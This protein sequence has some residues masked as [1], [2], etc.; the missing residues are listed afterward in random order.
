MGDAAR[1]RRRISLIVVT[2]NSAPLVTTAID[3]AVESAVAAD[4]ELEIIVVDNASSDGT[5]DL[6]ERQY[7]DARVLRNAANVGFAA[8][9]NQAFRQASGDVWLLLNPDATVERSAL[10]H[11]VGFLDARGRAAAAA[12]TVEDGRGGGAE[13]AGMTPGLRSLASH[14]LMINRLLVGDRGGA[15]RGF[16]LARRPRLGPRS[17]DWVGG[18]ALLSRAEAIRSVGGFDERFFLYGEDV[19]LGA[20]LRDRGW[21][22]WLVPAA[23][24][25]HLIAGSQGRVSTR[26]VDGLRAVYA[27]RSSRARTL[28]LDLIVALGLGL[29]AGAATVQP[30]EWHRRRMRAAARHAAGTLLRS[31][32]RRS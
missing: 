2:Y 26:W 32:V 31:L 1:S 6:V 19:D 18:M 27:R 14:F 13:S 10:R 20:R 11:L 17:V 16:Q 3:S 5:G 4:L 23:R 25:T 28:V 21:E 7:P 9:N 8:A 30:D 29:R 22:L 24:A 15:W 12:P